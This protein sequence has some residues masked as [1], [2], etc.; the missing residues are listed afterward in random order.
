MTL[1]LWAAVIVLLAALII[2]LVA[3][4]RCHDELR[5]YKQLFGTANALEGKV[6]QKTAELNDLTANFDQKTAQLNIVEGKLVTKN[7]ELLNL[8]EQVAH[9]KTTLIS[10]QVEDTT[11]R[12]SYEAKVQALNAAYNEKELR[13]QEQFRTKLEALDKEYSDKA[14]TYAADWE[15]KRAQLE[16]EY[17]VLVRT[18]HEQQNILRIALEQ[19]RQEHEDEGRHYLVMPDIDRYELTELVDVCGHI[20]NPLPL[21]K[22]MYDIYYKVPT[23]NLINDLGVKGV[24]GIYKITDTTNS[25]MYIGQSVDMGER[26]RQHIKRGIGAE[27]GTISGSKLYSAMMSN[28]LWNFKFELLEE[29]PKDNL[30]AREKFWISYFNATEYGYNMK[31][32][33]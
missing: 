30:N 4:Y 15:H 23:T 26:W 32:G 8:G 33:G 27:A 17:A 19:N 18:I 10:A 28:K 22:A 25:K 21:C 7:E 24:S 31:S 2:S 16:D 13:L 1:F 11:L 9:A 14:D 6:N 3:A 29:V 5:S 12:A 20:R